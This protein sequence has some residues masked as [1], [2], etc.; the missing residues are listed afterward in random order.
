MKKLLITLFSILILAG[1][2]T[3][4]E[5]ALPYKI[6]RI[7]TASA[8]WKLGEKILEEECIFDA[9]Y[10]ECYRVFLGVMESGQVLVQEFYLNDLK[11]TDPFFVQSIHAAKLPLGSGLMA[12]K[13]DGV[14]IVWHDNGQKWLEGNMQNGEKDGIWTYWN[15]DGQKAEERH[16]QNGDKVGIWRV[17]NR[18]GL[19]QEIDYGNP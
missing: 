9:I 1:C 16:Y 15:M 6:D 12:S 2:S 8:P 3:I 10:S 13:V 7:A 17:W 14:F 11:A 5:N 18:S 4:E 19:V